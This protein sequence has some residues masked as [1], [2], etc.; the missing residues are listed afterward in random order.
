MAR[1]GVLHSLALVS[2][3]PELSDEVGVNLVFV[4]QIPVEPRVASL[5]QQ[6]SHAH[7][8][9]LLP[10]ATG[11]V[12]IDGQPLDA[13]GTVSRR[14]L[15]PADAAP[16]TL[17]QEPRLVLRR[18]KSHAGKVAISLIARVTFTERLGDL[19]PRQRHE[20][21]LDATE[22][23]PP[24]GEQGSCRSTGLTGAEVAQAVAVTSA[25]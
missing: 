12:V 20:G 16:T 15:G 4:A 22:P 17:E 19:S 8:T 21:T 25:T 9:R 14:L 23:H 2:D 13:A 6:S 7:P 10:R 1:P 11:V 3:L 24:V 18:S 5:A